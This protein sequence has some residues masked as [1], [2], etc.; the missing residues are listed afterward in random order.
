MYL[1]GKAIFDEKFKRKI[2]KLII[3]KNLTVAQVA[4]DTDININTLY[5]WKKKYGLEF[6][7]SELPQMTERKRLKFFQQRIDDLRK[8]NLFLKNRL[9]YYLKKEG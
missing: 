6:I 1:M 3:E 2:V 4:R 7:H 8:E 5:S 9:S